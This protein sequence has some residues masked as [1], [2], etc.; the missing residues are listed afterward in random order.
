MYLHGTLIKQS[1]SG[2]RTTEEHCL[3]RYEPYGDFWEKLDVE[4]PS[5]SIGICAL[6][7]TLYAVGGEYWTTE[8]ESGE[9]DEDAVPGEDAEPDGDAGSG[10]DAAQNTC[11]KFY[12]IDL[13]G[14]KGKEIKSDIDASYDGMYSTIEPST[15]KLYI[16]LQ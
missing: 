8:E 5:G 10:D 16:F 9:E 13:S 12:K 6:G 7:D 4:M 15:D 11:L 2:E 1:E 3:W 14:G